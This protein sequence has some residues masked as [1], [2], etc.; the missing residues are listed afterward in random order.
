M[1]RLDPETTIKLGFQ[2]RILLL[3]RN[4][5]NDESVMI[6]VASLAKNKKLKCWVWAETMGSPPTLDPVCKSLIINDVVESNYTLFY[7]G[8]LPAD[9]VKDSWTCPG[10]RRCQSSSCSTEVELHTRQN[11]GCG[12]MPEEISMLEN[13]L[14]PQAPCLTL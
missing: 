8:M 12:T 4:F 14:S 13:P 11:V 9:L 2:P 5:I 10:S 6:L 1:S 7:L 3:N